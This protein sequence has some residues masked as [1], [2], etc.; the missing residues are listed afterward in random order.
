MKKSIK[1]NVTQRLLFINS[2]AQATQGNW[3]D[4]CDGCDEDGGSHQ[5][6]NHSC[7]DRAGC[8]WQV[9]SVQFLDDYAPSHNLQSIKERHKLVQ[10]TLPMQN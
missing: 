3:L 4:L 5:S 1:S 8:C 9:E 6:V 7:V 10:N 2:S